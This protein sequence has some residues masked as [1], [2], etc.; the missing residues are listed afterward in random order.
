M[1]TF[2]PS[3]V[4]PE[5]LSDDTEPT[6]HPDGLTPTENHL[7]EVQGIFSA[8]LA[9][10]GVFLALYLV[11]LG[12]FRTI[13]RFYAGQYLFQIIFFV[14]AGYLMRRRTARFVIKLGLLILVGL[15]GALLALGDDARGYAFLLGALAGMGEGLYWPGINLNEYIATHNRTRNLYYGKLFLYSNCASVL[16]LPL[17]GIVLY[18]TDDLWTPESGY[19]VLFALLMLMLLV[20]YKVSSGVAT[21]S[22]I[23]F[24]AGDF[25]RHRRST[26]WKLVLA[27]NFCRGLWAYTLPAYSAVLLFNIL[28]DAL[29]TDDPEFAL[30]VLSAAATIAVG[31]ASLVAGRIL[32]RQR[33]AYLVGAVVVPIGMIGFA[34]N[35]NLWGIVFYAL[36]ILCFETFAQNTQYKA[37]YDVM[38]NAASHWSTAYHF[39]VEREL[40]WNLGRVASFAALGLAF[41]DDNQVETLTTAIALIAILPIVNGGLQWAYH[42]A[43]DRE[44]LTS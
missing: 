42:R 26:A 32:Q 41:T 11:Q 24:S 34:F 4:S 20:T 27:Q 21:S 14:V 37:M 35:Q 2:D 12:D 36:L 29:G 13:A 8:A 39:I 19:Y 38:D 9:I 43:M 18:L 23:Q 33:S 28:S 7:I 25:L 22:G 31:L 5:V 15:Y 1:P 6:A 17:G 10:A 30:G 40:W 44:G 3:S 16:G